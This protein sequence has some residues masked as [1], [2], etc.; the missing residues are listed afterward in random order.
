M[1]QQLALNLGSPPAVCLTNFIGNAD[2]VLALK[3]LLSDPGTQPGQR[4]IYLCGQAGSGRSH[5][6]HASEAFVQA[7]GQIKRSLDRYSKVEDFAY[8]PYVTLYTVDDVEQLDNERQIALFNLF[9]QIVPGQK[10]ICSGAEPPLGLKVREDLRTRLAWGLVFRLTPL[11]DEEKITALIQAAQARGLQLSPEVPSW[12]INHYQRD[13]GSLMAVLDALDQFS[14]ERKR[15]V[16][17]PLLRELF[18]KLENE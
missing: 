18:A 7:A 16:T 4:N 10:L 1:A 11:N 15:A 8:L 6:L 12:L 17:L 5:L 9:N 2:V 3:E 14:L 13:L